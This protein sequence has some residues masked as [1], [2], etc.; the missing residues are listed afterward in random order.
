MRVLVF[1]TETTGLPSSRI[2]NPDTLKLWPHIVQFSYVIYDTEVNDSMDV[3]DY[4]IKLPNSV[5]ISEVVSNIHGITNDM[6]EKLGFKLFEV[7]N[8]HHLHLPFH[9]RIHCFMLLIF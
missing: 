4:I 7:L 2:I 5:V 9:K 3:R 6:S 1:D 8:I